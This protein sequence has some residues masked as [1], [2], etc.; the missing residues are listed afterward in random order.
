MSCLIRA[1]GLYTREFL[2]FRQISLEIGGRYLNCSNRNPAV[3]H[4]QTA[5][6][7]PDTN[8]ARLMGHHGQD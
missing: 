4:P 1:I 2:Y 8:I 6:N 7:L 5:E 3:D